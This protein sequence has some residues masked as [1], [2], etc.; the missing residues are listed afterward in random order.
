MKRQMKNTISLI[1][2]VILF[3]TTLI[4]QL[5]MFVSATASFEISDLKVCALD[6]PLGIDETPV[7]SWILT[8]DGR[9]QEQ[10]AYRIVLSTDAGGSN[11]VWD[12]GKVS[13]KDSIDIVYPGNALT[14]KTT[15]YWVAEVWCGDG[16]SVKSDVN[17]FST[18]ILDESEWEGQWITAAQEIDMTFTGTPQLY[19]IWNLNGRQWNL[20]DGQETIYFRKSFTVDA[21]KTVSKVYLAITCDDEYAYYLNGEYVA[22]SRGPNWS[23]GYMYDLTNQV[24]AAGENVL[25]IEGFNDGNAPNAAGLLAKLEVRYTD[26]SKDV[27][28]TNGGAYPEDIWK[29][30]RTKEEGWTTVAYDDSGWLPAD[31]LRKYGESP[32]NS[33]VVPTS[34]AANAR[35]EV[36]LRKEFNVSKQIKE[37]YAYVC[38]LG[39]FDFTLN[40]EN[41]DDTL[42]NPYTTQYSST[43]LYR[44]FNVTDM[45]Q[46]GDN[47]IGVGLGNS[48]YNEIAGVWNWQTAKWKDN[49]KLIFNLEI[50]YEDGSSEIIKSDT[51]WKATLDGPIVANSMYY[52]DVYD[53]RKELPGFNKVGFDDSQWRNAVPA[54]VPTGEK[55]AHM[56]APRR[57]VAE[58]TVEDIT[59]LPNGSYILTQPEM[60][61]G[62]IKLMNI[63]EEAGH[64]ITITYGQALNPDGTVIKWG[65]PD[66]KT[67]H[68]WPEFYIQQDNYIAKGTGNE[69]YEPKYSWKGHYYVQIDGFSG[70]L[71]KEDI[72]SYRVSNDV[73][74]ISEFETSNSMVNQLH[75]IAVS[76]LANNFQG[77]HCDP[78]L[79][80]NGWTGD[81]NIALGMLMYNFDMRGCLP[82]W[83]DVI[84]DCY[85]EYGNF[86]QMVPTANW[87]AGTNSI[88]WN[89]LLVYGAQ[90]LGRYFGHNSYE[91]K[92]YDIMRTYILRDLN[93]VKAN[94]PKWIWEA[95]QMGDWVSPIGGTNPNSGYNENAS[96]GSALVGTAFLYGMLEYMAELADSLGKSSEA[97]EYRD[98]MSYIYTAF[99]ENFYKADRQI[100]ETNY[101]NQIGA[102]TK[103]R[104][105]SNLVP[106][107]FGLVPDEHVDT[108][109][110]NL[111]KDIE[112]KDYH[113]DTGFI[114]TRYILPI[115]CQYGHE[116]LAFKILTQETYP[117]WGYMLTKSPVATWEMWENS[118]RSFDHYFLNTY[119][120]WFYSYI[121]G[122][123]DI[124][125]GYET[126]TVHPNQVGD[127]TYANATIDTVRGTLVSNWKLNEDDTVTMDVTVPFGSTATVFFP[128]A[129]LDGA[130]L[131]GVVVDTALDGIK[132]VE[133]RDGQLC[134]TVGSGVYSFTSDAELNE[135]KTVFSTKLSALT[136]S[137]GV[138]SPAFRSSHTDYSLKLGSDW[139]KLKGVRVTPTA[140]DPEAI[141]KINDEIV[142]SGEQSELIPIS[143]LEGK[144][145]IRVSG[146]EAFEE[147][148]ISLSSDA[149]IITPA[150]IVAG[151]TYSSQQS[152]QHL[153]DGSGMSDDTLQALHDA[154]TSGGTMWHTDNYPGEKAWVKVDLGKEYSLDEMWIWNINQGVSDGPARGFKNVKIEYSTDNATWT[155]LQPP[156][157]M[158][159]MD[160]NPSIPEDYPFQFTM[161]TGKPNLPATNLNDGNQTPVSFEGAL[162]R[163]V[164]ISAHPEIGNGNWGWTCYGLSALRFTSRLSI[165]PDPALPV[166][167]VEITHDDIVAKVLN[168]REGEQATLIANV[169]PE[170]ADNKAVSW[171]SDNQDIVKVDEEGRI[172][173]ISEGEAQITVTTEDGGFTDSI[174]V[175][176]EAS[177][178]IVQVTKVK[179]NASGLFT[180]SIKKKAQ[181]P[182]TI[183]PLDATDKTIK[184]ISTNTNIFTVDSDGNITPKKQ[185]TA[186]LTA[187]SANGL[188]STIIV[189]ITA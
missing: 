20:I 61:A 63:N 119:D 128:T 65:G 132:S 174:T 37:A 116:K 181:I 149:M 11:V 13:S 2:A 142:V 69:S 39:F 148:T 138:L 58:F 55:K 175:V 99:N 98:A 18:G 95:G 141:I 46:Q 136:V 7:F 70:D 156:E 42:L 105:T 43:V 6:T 189:R 91:V 48:F 147:Y 38:G 27:H 150:G 88:I 80:K 28:A 81:A 117:S 85:Y 56:K 74:T 114:G 5:G 71:K 184:W 122:I 151:Q 188:K 103:Y 45:L 9:A 185:G 35:A 72:I 161:A 62:W 123:T 106:L 86:S 152:E 15:Y 145:T 54:K 79:E 165:E 49:P 25:A 40:G 3:T 90:D 29:L 26:G 67:N 144:I 94:N 133:I 111:V 23:K 131:D 19:W 155:A 73:D 1:L 104:Q 167:G 183:E 76:S 12:S 113:L 30:S 124:K 186:T 140:V 82:G 57:R 50:K 36:L 129:K 66:G 139:D 143:D 10:S 120:E 118:T 89:S 162:A 127:L 17:V 163:Y 32:W 21:E 31:A 8:G 44:T 97:A 166:E 168:M 52:G 173:A 126:F 96:E 77:E 115:L 83:L 60:I 178:E 87:A 100:Y 84:E 121:A 176:V 59:K 182:V 107:A 33:N 51:S 146:G 177:G 160:S 164:R 112:E 47:A 135:N 109:V 125:N 158:T 137:E 170:D 187:Q 41:P 93:T 75:Q 110:A 14:A 22:E 159:F 157:D 179:I 171:E 68:W 101:W 180:L 92:Q 134:V 108:I 169:W 78:L 153:I 64:K 154:P 172:T 130:T 34:S 24:N 102:R 53:A 16:E 4:P